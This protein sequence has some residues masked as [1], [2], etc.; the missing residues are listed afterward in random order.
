MRL[1][2]WLCIFAV[3]A[4]AQRTFT[5]TLDE[6]IRGAVFDR[7][8][9]YTWGTALLRWNPTTGTQRKIAGPSNGTFGEGGCLDR[10][11]TLYLQDGAERGPFVSIA[12]DGKRTVL[13]R[14]VEMHDCVATD[15]LGHRG[16]LITDHYGQVRFYEGPGL[17]RELYSFYTPSRQAGLLRSDIDGDGLND[18]LAGNYWIRSPRAF[19]LPWRLFAINTRHETVDSATMSLALSGRK[20]FAA[21]GHMR[22][23]KLLLYTPSPDV[24]QLWKEQTIATLAYPHALTTAASGEIVVGENNGPGSRLFITLGGDHL[25]LIGTTDGVH[26]VFAAGSR[27]LAVGAKTVS[28]WDRQRLK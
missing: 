16:V 24:T 3:P 13:D 4:L 26:T 19:E 9:L 21:Q 10:R 15:L 12:P 17:Y 14:R 22:E 8:T 7:G 6:H 1:T 18:I 28:W 11:G 20:L 25:L 27:I 23:G 2:V 5:T